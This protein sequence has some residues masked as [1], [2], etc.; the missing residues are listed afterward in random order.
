MRR[1]TRSDGIT[2]AR[3]Q[4]PVP[5]LAWPPV[6]EPIPS[7]APLLRRCRNNESWGK[8]AQYAR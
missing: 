4:T 7:A 1:S 8:V 5:Q 2:P 3:V 6:H